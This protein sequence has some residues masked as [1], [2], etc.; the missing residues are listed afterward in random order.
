[1]TNQN[2]ESSPES[3][4]S[5][6]PQI[7]KASFVLG[8]IGPLMIVCQVCFFIVFFFLPSGDDGGSQLLSEVDMTRAVP[9]GLSAAFLV[10]LAGA[11]LGVAG[12]RSRHGLVIAGLVLNAATLVLA[13]IIGAIWLWFLAVL[14]HAIAC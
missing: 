14:E 7:G 1:M 6:A 4:L 9:L 12:L 11:C 13:L 10:A 8:L 5:R 2:D 3:A